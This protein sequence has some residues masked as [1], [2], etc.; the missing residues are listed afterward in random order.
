V[1]A[2]TPGT[3][4]NTTPAAASACASPPRG[5]KTNGSPPLSRTTVRWRRPRSTRNL[6]YLHLTHRA[7]GALARID[8]LGAGGD[9]LEQSRVYEAVVDNRVRLAQQRPPANRE[10]AG[11]ARS[12]TDEMDRHRES[13]MSAGH[14]SGRAARLRGPLRAPAARA[15]PCAGAGRCAR[16]RGRSSPRAAVLRRRSRRQAPLPGARSL[17]PGARG[18]PARRA[19]AGATGSGRSMP[20]TRSSPRR[21]SGIRPRGAPWPTWGS[22]TDTV[23]ISAISADRPR[24]SSAAAATTAAPPGG[25]LAEPRA[26][27]PAQFDKQRSG[28]SHASCAGGGQ[29]PWQQWRRVLGHRGGPDECVPHVAA[30]GHCR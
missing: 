18:T 22:I 23:S 24:R 20:A 3:I 10:Q 6:V 17:R 26:D 7:A 27:V 1:A 25:I 8:Q 14:R 30:F 16:P 2:L 9:D 15:P 29:S 13:S 5:R 11:V 4:S 12:G 28:R 19:R 21:R